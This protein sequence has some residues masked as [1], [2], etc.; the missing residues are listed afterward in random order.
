MSPKLNPSFKNDRPAENKD[1]A[2]VVDEHLDWLIDWHRLAFMTPVNERL[3][4]A[5]QFMPPKGFG[6]WIKQASKN[7]PQDQPVIEKLSTLHDQMH[8]L[9]RLVLLR[10]DSANVSAEDYAAVTAKFQ[11]LIAGLRRL[12]RAFAIAASGLDLLTGLRSRVGMEEDIKSELN[13]FERTHKP[14]CLAIM[15]IDHFKSVNDTY[16]HDAGDQVLATAADIVSQQTRSFDDVYRLG[17]EEFLIC[18]KEADSKE[19]LHTLDRL[20]TSLAAAP[21]VLEHHKPL[22]IT[23]SFGFT[24]AGPGKTVDGMLHEADQALYKAKRGGRNRI[25]KA[26]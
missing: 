21:I 2:R 19:A 3:E 22:Y 12:E 18:L 1:L 26:P 17:G 24:E 6:L 13:R 14:F 8:T 15:D 25:E 11:I 5:K 23:A 9:A 4:L 10:G 20:R 16:G 7:L